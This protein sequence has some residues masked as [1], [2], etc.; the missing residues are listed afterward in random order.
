[1]LY[2]VVV[3][4]L[5]LVGALVSYLHA[6][7][8]GTRRGGGHIFLAMVLI[9]AVE[10]ALNELLPQRHIDELYW[11]PLSLLCVSMLSGLVPLW[12]RV[13]YRGNNWAQIVALRQRKALERWC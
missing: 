2:Y 7:R 5:M 12:R 10:S 11:M 4:A 1:M 9:V 8:F 3:I 13:G 6:H